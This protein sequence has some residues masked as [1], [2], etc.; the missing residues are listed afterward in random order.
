MSRS[1]DLSM[2]EDQQDLATVDYNQPSGADDTENRSEQPTLN[3]MLSLKVKSELGFK[4]DEEKIKNLERIKQFK[5]QKGIASHVKVQ[6][7][8]LEKK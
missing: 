7:P 2:Q 8:K 5:E 1:R 3:R 6:M 4:K